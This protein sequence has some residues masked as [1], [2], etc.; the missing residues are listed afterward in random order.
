MNKH[1]YLIIAHNEPEVLKTLLA[2]LDDVRNDIFVHID[3][4]ARFVYESV[5]DY[6]PKHST[7][8]FLEHPI[9][10]YWGDISQVQVEY[11]LFE[12]AFSQGPYAYYHL[13]SGVDLPIKSQDYIHAFFQQNQGKEFVGFWMDAAHRRDLKRK[14]YRYYLFT[15]YFKG[16]NALVHSVCALSRNLFLALQKVIRYKRNQGNI[17]FQKGFN[18]V[19]IT[20]AFCT[21]LLSQKENVFR[22]FRYTL[23]PDEIFIQT[24]LWNSSF[25]EHIYNKENALIG[26]MRYIDWERGNPY[27]WQEKDTDELLSSPYL[28]A[29]KFASASN[30]RALIRHIQ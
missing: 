12:R 9:A 8:V 5:K 1:A 3:R 17:V 6:K 14:V 28:F 20:Q 23:C 11:M 29:R 25:R 30:V 7:L 16:G 21:Y 13:L 4:R 22:T 18:W 15:R 27:V 2:M 26:S 19:S 10:V 24:V